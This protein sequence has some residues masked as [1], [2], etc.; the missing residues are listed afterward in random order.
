M[1]NIF[2]NKDGETFKKV[3]LKDLKK[4]DEFKRKPDANKSFVKGDYNRKSF[5][6]PTASY[7]CIPDDDV[8]GGGMEINSKA[9]VYIDS[10]GALNYR[11]E[12]F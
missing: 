6:N 11:R 8:W 9:F 10:E 7:T 2:T 4:G 3:A 1:T 12:M 5:F